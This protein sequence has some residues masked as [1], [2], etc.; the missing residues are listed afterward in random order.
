MTVLRN[1]FTA[2]P[3]GT[4]ITNTNSG[5]GEDDAFDTYNNSAHADTILKFKSAEGLDR[6]TAEFVM[7]ASTG[8]VAGPVYLAWYSSMGAQTQFWVRFYCFFSAAPDNAL[9]PVM[10]QTLELPSARRCC[11]G[12]VGSGGGGVHKLFSENAPGTVQVQS[13]TGIIEGSWFRVEARF[14]CHTSTG[15]GEI[16]Y[17]EDADSDTPTDT[18]TFSSWNLGG[19]QSDFYGFGYTVSDANLETMYL[20]GIALSDEDWIGPEP[21]K[22]KGVPGIQPNP[23]AIHTDTW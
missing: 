19:S 23:V 5:G 3:D 15:N 11:I 21:F 17:Y 13:S 8:A 10:F 18:M 20:S 14:Q 7:R 9:S 4:D 1:N 16:R 22:I 2:G 6:N 12:V